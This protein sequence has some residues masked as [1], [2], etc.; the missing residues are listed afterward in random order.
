MTSPSIPP[1]RR[2]KLPT[3]LQTIDGG[4]LYGIGQLE[5]RMD[6]FVT[7]QMEIQASIDSQTSLMHDLFGHFGINPDD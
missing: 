2:R 3:I 4:N 1:Q 5:R 7:V 6:D